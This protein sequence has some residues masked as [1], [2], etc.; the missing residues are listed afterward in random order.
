MSTKDQRGFTLIE[1]AVVAP[2]MILVA[3]GIV[4]ILITLVTSTLRPNA[5]SIVM[6]QEQKAMD[7]IESDI[8][9][10]SGLITDLPSNF[11]DGNAAADYYDPPAGTAVI[12]I[13]TYDQ[14]VNPNDNSGTKVIPAFKDSAS[15]CTNITD[16]SASNIVPIVVVYFVKDNTLYRRTLTQYYGSTPANTCGTKLAKQTCITCTNKDIVLIAADSISAFS[17]VYYTGITNDVVTTD[18]T[19]AKSAK[20]TITASINAG[21]DAVEYTSTLRAS[22]L[23]P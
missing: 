15:S 9:N 17:V 4:A 16:L 14:I 7:S 8:N 11:S 5:R 12:G 6:Q 21:G 20:I 10:S 2:I 1:V 13:Q 18:P 19:V 22:R 3:L 23:N